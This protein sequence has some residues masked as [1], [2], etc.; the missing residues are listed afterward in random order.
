M[1]T[2]RGHFEHRAALIFSSLQAATDGLHALARGKPPENASRGLARLHAQPPVAFL[3]TGQGAQHRGMG[4]MLFESEPVFRDAILRCE[5]VLQP[6]LAGRLTELLFAADED[7]LVQTAV[8]Q[9]ALFALEYG[10]TELWASWGV[11]PDYLLGHSLGEYVA[12]CVAGIFSLE[13]A[14]RLVVER[15]RLMQE[16]PGDGSMAAFF[17]D[18]AKL[19]PILAGRED[20]LAIAALNAP[21]EIVLSGVAVE[22]ETAMSEM[23]RAGVAARKLMVSHAFHSPLMRPM[24][25]EFE[26][27]LAG[28]TFSP[29][30]RAIALN[31]TGALDVSHAM[32]SPAYWLQQIVSPVHFR[33]GLSALAAAGARV[34]LEIGPRPVLTILGRKILPDPGRTWVATLRGPQEDGTT[35]LRGV[36]ELYAAGVEIDWDALHRHRGGKK[37]AL[38]TYPFQRRR[39]WLPKVTKQPAAVAR[40]EPSEVTAEPPV[41]D[42]RFSVMFFA[43]TQNPMDGDKYRLVLESARFADRHG[44]ASVWVPER[45]FTNMGSLYPNPAVLH[46][47][48]AR[49]TRRVRLMAGSVVAPLHHPIRLAE[50]WAM[51]DNLSGGRVGLSLASGWNP[52]DFAFFPER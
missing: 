21:G 4:Y 19:L 7:V 42:V 36:A 37:L 28:V 6:H 26:R 30:T 40:K 35:S 47:A 11:R 9:P 22:L 49:E 20:R 8:A 38:P 14:L 10:L 33:G 13:D 41:K 44:F 2:G 24:L 12:A 29:P 34:F 27:L 43:A 52:D 48:L 39:F 46:A 16:L 45:H 18:E 3:F 51:V 1:S 25:A 15:G 31:V 17:A 5:K 23:A 50:E 32:A